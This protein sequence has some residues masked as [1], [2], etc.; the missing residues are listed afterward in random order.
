VSLR[1]LLD[2]AAERESEF[3]KASILRLHAGN[4]GRWPPETGTLVQRSECGVIIAGEGGE[5]REAPGLDLDAVANARGVM[6][7]RPTVDGSV[8]VRGDGSCP[9]EAEGYGLESYRNGAWV[10]VF[11]R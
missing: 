1:R 11:P 7:L 9:G 3:L 4:G 2:N 8:R 6:L 5:A 10:R